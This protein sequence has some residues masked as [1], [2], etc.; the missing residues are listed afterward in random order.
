MN[1]FDTRNGVSITEIADNIA[2]GSN[3]AASLKP[4]TQLI[5]IE[6]QFFNSDKI[7]RGTVSCTEYVDALNSGEFDGRKLKQVRLF[8]T[9][10]DELGTCN[11]VYSFE[12]KLKGSPA[13]LL[14]LGE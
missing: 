1:F 12:E 13:F 7:L 10:E 6:F 2:S 14:Q 4:Y 9:T 11:F 8:S 5:E 3:P